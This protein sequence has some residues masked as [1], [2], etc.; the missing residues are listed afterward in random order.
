M[1]EGLQNSGSI[2][3]EALALQARRGSKE[4]EEEL[5]LRYKNFVR[6]KARPYYLTG[7]DREDLIQ[8]GMIGLYKAVRDFNQEKEASFRSFADLCVT[9]QI[10]T[11]I[12]N[13]TR[14]KHQPLNSYIS[15]NNPVFTDNPDRTVEDLAASDLSSSPEELIIAEESVL[16][17]QEVIKSKLSSFEIQVLELYMAGLPYCDI[18]QRLSKPVKSVDNALQR[19]KHKLAQE[20]LP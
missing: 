4:A 20:L 8:E 19:I 1:P 10:L 5:L 18:A 12:K 14:N 16:R 2:S 13:A 17:A 3:D 9:R 11:A 15:L 7:S 6:A